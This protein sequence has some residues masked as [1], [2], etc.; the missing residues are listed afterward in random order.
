ML[1][2]VDFIKD[3]DIEVGELI[4]CVTV[5]AANVIRDLQE[6]IRNLVG[7]EMTHYQNLIESGIERALKGLE[8]KAQ[9]KGYDGVLGL[10]IAN[11]YVVDGAIEVIVYG[12][13]FK[14]KNKEK[15]FQQILAN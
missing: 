8:Q 10:K 13:G 7:G 14:Y 2:T 12:N 1:F 6:N 15:K 4:T 9:D 5:T 3:K 11:P